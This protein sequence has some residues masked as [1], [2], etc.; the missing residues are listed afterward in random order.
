M[1]A[2]PTELVHISSQLSTTSICLTII[3]HKYLI[4]FGNSIVL[5]KI[6]TLLHNQEFIRKLL[7][8]RVTPRAVLR[9]FCV[10]LT[11]D[12][13]GQCVCVCVCVSVCVYVY[14]CVC[15][16]L[17]G[18]VCTIAKNMKHFETRKRFLRKKL[19]ILLSLFGLMF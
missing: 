11:C 10:T 8:S 9:T 6:L 13:E 3:N 17:G 19:Y 2:V 14:V 1:R 16:C 4:I 7:N 18:C 15:V 12:N 5:N